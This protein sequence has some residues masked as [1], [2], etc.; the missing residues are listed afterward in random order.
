MNEWRPISEAP[1]DR[2]ELRVRD[3]RGAEGTCVYE[4]GEWRT[5]RNKFRVE[6]VSFLKTWVDD[7]E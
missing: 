7:G 3:A 6:A 4:K 5:S 2:G 1:K